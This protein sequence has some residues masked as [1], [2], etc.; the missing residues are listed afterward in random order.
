MAMTPDQ[1]QDLIIEGLNYA[2][3]RETGSSFHDTDKNRLWGSEHYNSG[4]HVSNPSPWAEGV[5]EE[6]MIVLLRWANTLNRNVPEFK[7]AQDLIAQE[8]SLVGRIIRR[9]RNTT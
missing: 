9:Y 8:E 7:E 3:Y 4:R 6:K 5:F 1:A 2:A